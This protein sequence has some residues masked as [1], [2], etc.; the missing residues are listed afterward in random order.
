MENTEEVRSLRQRVGIMVAPPTPAAVV[1]QLVEIEEAG[2]DNVWVATGPVFS[3]DLLTSLAAAAARTSR[4]KFGTSI[5]QVTSRHPVFMAQQLLS[6][7]SLAPGRVT[8][9]LGT[10]SLELAKSIYGT[11]VKAALAYLREYVQVLR[12]LLQQ[13]EVHHQG[14][15]F[16][17]GVKLQSA[18]QVPLFI[19]ALG[20]TAF[21]L[22]GEIADGALPFMCPIPYLLDTAIPA[23]NAG[24]AAAGRSRP[25]IVAH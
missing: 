23:L 25:P 20:P 13:G 4:L 12:P 22:A 7:A 11:E 19:S 18:S 15:Q 1:K 8:I 6:L 16:T 9:G 17:T 21:R 2:V 5:V 3:P 10:G 24:A 14:V